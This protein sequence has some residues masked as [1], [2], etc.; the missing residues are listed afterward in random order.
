MARIRYNDMKKVAKKKKKTFCSQFVI[1][2][3]LL[4]STIVVL[5]MIVTNQS[6]VNYGTLEILSITPT[7]VQNKPNDINNTNNKINSTTA[8]AT[9]HHCINDDFHPQNTVGV[10][11]M[12]NDNM[13]YVK[14]AAKLGIGVRAKT[15]TPLDL[16][17]M[18][19]KTKP[20]SDEMW[21]ILR[22]AGFIKCSVESI[23][24]PEKTRSDLKEKFAV[25]HVWAMEVYET[26]VFLDADT[27]V[28]NSIDD[29]IHMDL[30]GKPV[31][32]TK[33]IRARKWVETF[34]SGVMVL[35]P[36]MIE[37]KRLVD[38]LYSGLKFDY[39]MSDQGFLNEVY[40]DNWHEIGFVNNANLALYL[41]QRTFWDEHKLEDINIIHYTMQK[42][43][44]CRPN[45]GYGPICKLWI[46]AFA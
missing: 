8:T 21:D 24:A 11:T 34:N 5:A 37:H 1:F 46:N 18:E 28:Q 38:L 15:K 14:G 26:V 36:S 30:K 3:S 31:G 13:D 6:D 40:K 43:W 4:L 20:L 23:K 32:V 44:K 19:L 41:F 42:P 22:P 7:V 29:L 10:W 45:G 9:A 39:I 25:L 16:V 27:F 2:I 12:L 35:H 33:D 17:V